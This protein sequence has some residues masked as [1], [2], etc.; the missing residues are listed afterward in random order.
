M[1]PPA[2]PQERP[3]AILPTMGGQTA[4]NLAK[5]LSEVRAA[6]ACL[7]ECGGV[8]GGGSAG[9]GGGRVK[10]GQQG[11]AAGS[12]RQLC[13]RSLLP[14]SAPPPTPCPPS[15]C[16]QSGI[17]AKYNVE[18]IG[19]KLESI[20][21]AED[22]DL[23][24]QA[25]K[26]LNLNMS[27]SRIATTMEECMKAA[28]E[29]G[30]MPLIIRPAFTLGG[31]GGGIAYNMDE[32]RCGLV[33]VDWWRRGEGVDEGEGE[34]GLPAHSLQNARGCWPVFMPPPP[35]PVPLAP[36][37]AICRLAGRFATRA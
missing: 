27:A 18:L 23:F 14:Q 20:N 13:D 7:P 35:P 31:T 22:R 30:S 36:P 29:I 5:A 9:D 3:D 17:L 26:K 10:A 33:G 12:C 8:G 34:C 4:L 25:M 2:C 16:P 24:A 37:A 21:K 28:E 15:P 6:L 19:A 11:A 1:P 32:F